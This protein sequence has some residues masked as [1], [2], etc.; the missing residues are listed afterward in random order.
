VVRC[1]FVCN[2]KS[3]LSNE[4]DGFYIGFMPVYAGSKENEEFFKYTPAGQLE[5]QLVNKATADQIECGKEYY[6]DISPAE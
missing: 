2:S 5:L 6:I 3:S 4:D 1:K